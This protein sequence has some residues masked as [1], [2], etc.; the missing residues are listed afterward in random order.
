MHTEVEHHFQAPRQEFAA[1]LVMSEV[2]THL[3]E[4]LLAAH[5]LIQ[6]SNE[7]QTASA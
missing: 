3:F 6:Y 5:A 1:S 7:L 4:Q 2:L